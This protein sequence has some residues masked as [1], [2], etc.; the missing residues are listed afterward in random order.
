MTKG[1]FITFEG[2]DGSGKTTQLELAEKFLKQRG[3]DVVTT[4]EP[5]ALEIGEK[6][7]NILLN[8]NGVVSDKCEMF[9]F[10]A[11]RAQHV[12]TFIKPALESGKIVLCDRYTDSTI[13]YQGYARGQ[14]IELL[15]KLNNIAIRGLLPDLT[16]LYDI[17]TEISQQRIGKEKDR[18][19]SS[20]SIF[21]EKV[22]QGYLTI[23]KENPARIKKIDGTKSIDEVFEETKEIILQL[24]Q[25]KRGV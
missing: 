3:Y 14:D 17:P 4:R 24:I 11:D 18:M 22:H 20:G 2:I 1:Y 8:Y 13:A 10:L 15:M 5:G 25:E 21:H 23:L 16:L 6:I 19:E 9:L 7:R 12:E